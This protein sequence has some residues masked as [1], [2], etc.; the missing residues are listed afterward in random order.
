MHMQAMDAPDIRWSELTSEEAGEHDED[1]HEHGVEYNLELF[2]L[3]VVE[4]K[5]PDGE[6]LSED[7]PRWHMS[8]E[9]LVDLMEYLMS[10]P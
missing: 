7:M 9:D 6:P 4:G 2:R 3:A 10:L 1:E 8:D 5:H